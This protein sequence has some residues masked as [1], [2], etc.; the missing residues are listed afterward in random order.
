MKEINFDLPER[1]DFDEVYKD[2]IKLK[3]G[4]IVNIPRYN[5]VTSKK[6]IN[7]FKEINPGKLIIIEGIYTLYD[8]VKI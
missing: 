6:E 1:I 3:N 4:E 8:D 7:N 2:L 5:M